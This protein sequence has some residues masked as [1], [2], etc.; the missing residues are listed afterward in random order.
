MRFG[1]VRLRR[2]HGQQRP[3][4]GRLRQEQRRILLRLLLPHKWMQQELRII[5]RAGQFI[6]RG[7]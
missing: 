2:R 5:L 1:T 6:R 4:H 7:F 3:G